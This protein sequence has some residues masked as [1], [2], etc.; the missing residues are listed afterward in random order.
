LAVIEPLLI[1]EDYY[2]RVEGREIISNLAKAAGLATMI[3][4]M[5][6]DI[7]SPDEY[8]RNTTS[9]AFAVV[10]SALGVTSL[11]PFLKA[12]CQS[13]KSW[14]ARHTG[15]KIVQQI[16][17]LMG[18]AVLP[19]LRELVDI[20]SHGLTDDMQKV[21]TITAL[22][23]S[24]LAEAAYPF[25]IESFD[26]IIRPLWKGALEHHGKSLAAFLKAIGYVIPLMEES[27]ASHYTR[28]VM[29]I[30]L[31]EFNSP[32]EEMKKIVLKVIQQCVATAGVE[33]DYIRTEIL[34]EFFRNFW[35]RRMALDRR[36]YQQVVETTEE[37]ANKV[38]CSDIVGRIVD[39]L[40]DDSE[41]YR[42]MVMET[43]QKVLT[44]LGAG[45]IDERLEERLIDGMLYA[46]QEQAVEA[47]VQS[48]PESQI[49]LDG[50]GTVVNALGERCKP[51]LKQIAGTIKWR[52]NNKAASVR[53]QAADLIGRIAVVMKAC[54]EDQLMGH[55]GVVLYEYLGEEYPE[56]L[57]SIL[58]ALRAIVNVIGMTKMTPPIQDL[59]P[60]LTPILR[61][62]HEKVQENCIDLV[63]T[64]CVTHT[65]PLNF[66]NDLMKLSFFPLPL[67][68]QSILIQSMSN[69]PFLCSLQV[70][71]IADR[72]A[73]FVSAKEW[74][75]ICFELLEM[76]KAHKKAIRRAAVST[77]GYIARAIGPQDVLHT[78]LNN[79]KVQDRQMRVCT[80]VAIAI[81]AETCGPFTVLPAIM[82][83]YRVPELNIQNGVLKALSFM[84]EYIGEMG[85]DYI[86]AVTPLLEDALMDRD[87]VHRQTG[88]ATVKHLALGVA[89]TGCEDALTHL[90][91]FVWPNIFEES[92][93]VINAVLDAVQGLMVS[94][95]PN[96]ILQYLLQGLYHPARKVRE[97]V[98]KVFNM[99]YIYNADALVMG[100]PMIED[101]GENTFARTTLELFI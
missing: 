49:M 45:D 14:Q 4:T 24:A 32:D 10:A 11:L 8:V 17:L 37:L 78:L 76:L 12:V 50:F 65:F 34:P 89:G 100:Y 84:F 94:L 19:Y 55:L 28:L 51:Y 68:G 44:N 36:N 13:R 57:G 91:N 90:L 73:E 83:E 60:R 54:G 66:D 7:D 56:V 26:S 85:K 80:T 3:A 72:G 92:P 64:T 88:C 67:S 46:F 87:P 95:G 33:P 15:I 82:N 22:T 71:R 61:N 18:C 30:L 23:V 42:R 79:L 20:V 96:V 39:D 29:P 58:G 48:N 52:L 6:P 31:R 53:M 70:G 1:D 77:F 9:R 69:Y 43:I 81:V 40:K 86:Y 75:R 2:A 5:R 62:R 99:L 27:Y 16:A 38:G 47:G 93:H 98:W 59:L 97:S 21:R 25:G 41:P 101:E 74:M 63:S 35:I